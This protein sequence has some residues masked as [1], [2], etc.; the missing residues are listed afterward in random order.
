MPF[1]YTNS[2]LTLP[3]KAKRGDFYFIL[4]HLKF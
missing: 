4:A 1:Y 2:I 3:A